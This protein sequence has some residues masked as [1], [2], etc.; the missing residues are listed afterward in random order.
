MNKHKIIK[1]NKD[2]VTGSYIYYRGICSKFTS[3]GLESYLEGLTDENLIKD[4]S[5]QIQILAEYSNHKREKLE[6]VKKFVYF[7]IL[8]AGVIIMFL[9][10]SLF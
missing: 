1:W 9:V 8:D 10:L 2:H 6:K 3:S 7:T 5:N 4:L